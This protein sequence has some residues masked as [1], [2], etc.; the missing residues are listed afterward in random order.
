MLNPALISAVLATAADGYR[1]ESDHG[2]PWPLSFVVAPLVLHRKTRMA[3]PSNTRTH[4]TSWT[5][6]NPVLR[7]GF[8]PRAQDPG[9][10]GE[11]GP[12]VRRLARCP[13]L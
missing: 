6:R 11:G 1:K 13:H 12:A 7:A 3:L 9:R 5:S 2:M 10:P 4:L 8:P